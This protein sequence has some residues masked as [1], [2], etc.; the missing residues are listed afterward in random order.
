MKLKV[1]QV[2]LPVAAK[3]RIVA[4]VGAEGVGVGVSHAHLGL[5]K[6]VS[7]VRPGYVLM[8]E[9]QAGTITMISI[10]HAGDFTT[11]S[12]SDRQKLDIDLETAARR[13]GSGVL[14]FKV[15]RPS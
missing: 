11:P 5:Q 7:Q 8:D 10:K 9:G 14:R 1:V 13:S 2:V 4:V 6:A 15:V 12:L 3:Q